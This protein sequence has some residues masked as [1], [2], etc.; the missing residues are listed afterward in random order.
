M[1]PKTDPLKHI[2]VP[3]I[4]V[5]PKMVLTFITVLQTDS[6]RGH[7]TLPINEIS[8]PHYFADGGGAARLSARRNGRILRWILRRSDRF[9]HRPVAHKALTVRAVSCIKVPMSCLKI[10]P[11]INLSAKQSILLCLL[12]QRWMHAFIYIHIHLERF[13]RL[14]YIIQWF[15]MRS[16]FVRKF[17]QLPRL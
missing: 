4:S 6:T 17:D 1:G 14:M 8:A 12:T 9:S 15:C 16:R 13:C 10:T 2:R 11:I 3:L 7:I 5:F